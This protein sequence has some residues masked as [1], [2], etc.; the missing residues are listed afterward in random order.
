[1]ACR[2]FAY[3]VTRGWTPGGRCC[4]GAPAAVRSSSGGS[5]PARSWSTRSPGRSGPMRRPSACARRRS[6][7]GSGPRRTVGGPAAARQRMLRAAAELGI[8]E[9]AARLPGWALIRRPAG[10]CRLPGEV[11][12]LVSPILEWDPPTMAMDP[13][14]RAGLIL[15]NKIPSPTLFCV[16]KEHLRD[17]MTP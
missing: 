7:H 5:T 9:D 2:T 6:G 14:G 3:P 11:L 12:R 8:H 10:P 13:K 1:M 16:G 4:A 15:F 17:G